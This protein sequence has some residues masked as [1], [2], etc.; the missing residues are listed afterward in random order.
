MC[1][2]ARAITPGTGAK[3][4]T[5]HPAPSTAQ[6]TKHQA[7]GTDRV[8]RDIESAHAGHSSRKGLPRRHR[9]QRRVRRDGRVEPDASGHRRGDAGRRRRSSTARKY[10]THVRPWEAR[11]RKA[12]GEKEPQFFLDTKEQPYLTPDGKPFELIR[13]WGHG[14]KTNVWGRVSLR[15]SDLDFKGAE[16]DGWEIPWPIEYKDVAPYYDKVDQLIGVYG[17]DDDSDSLPGSKYFM[18]PPAM[19]CSERLLKKAFESM[20]IPV[21]AGR[22]ANKTLPLDGYPA[23]HYCGNCGSRLRRGRVVL[24]GGS[25]A[26]GRAE[27][28]QARTAIERRGGAGPR[29]RERP[30]QGRPVLRPRDRAGAARCSRRSSSWARRRWTRR[31]SCSTRSR[32]RIPTGSATAPTSSAATSASRFAFMSPASCPSL[33][34]KEIVHDYGAGGEHMY[35]PRFKHRPARAPTTSAATACSSGIQAASR[36]TCR[37]SA[38]TST[39]FGAGFKREIKKRYPAWVE[40]HPFGETLPVRAQ[41]HHGRRNQRRHVRRAAAEDRLCNR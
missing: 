39:G 19:R 12:K 2:A 22:R 15:Y 36:A 33:Y 9:R 18:P 26:A 30:G 6:G 34:G 11:A 25:P 3:H 41:P 38:P 14:G 20:N 7:P 31:A 28:R 10:W 27:D 40:L 17:G 35:L 4:R 21:V 37:R 1:R 29:G 23:C 13:V 16:K 32:P 5:R 8:R 24:L